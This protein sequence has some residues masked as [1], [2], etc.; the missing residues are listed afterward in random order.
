MAI[1]TPQGDPGDDPAATPGPDAATDPRPAPTPGW[2]PDGDRHAFR[3]A[4]VATVI[5]LVALVVGY[6]LG[7]IEARG[8]RNRV[9]TAGCAVVFL[10]AG[11][12]AA[13]S[14]AHAAGRRAALRGGASAAA[15]VRLSCLIVG[16][17]AVILAALDLGGIDLGHLFTGGVLL[18]AVI[19]IASQQVLG[20]LF[21]GLVL[22]FS[23]PYRPG[24]RVRVLAGAING[25]HEGTVDSMD[26][27]YTRL[28]TDEGPINIPNA[29]LLAAA[30][31]P[32]ARTAAAEDET[33]MTDE[34]AA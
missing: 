24:E 30:V 11:V 33:P 23:R 19:G 2:L 18:A 8:A 12:L 7:G 3:R 21:A 25:P 22:L 4:L 31:G 27:L 14:A 16:Y 6:R 15:V 17:V 32:A 28:L 13:R 9:I 20:N 1:P 5:A 34:P 26:L 29:V 10:I